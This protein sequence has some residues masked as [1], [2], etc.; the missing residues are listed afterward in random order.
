MKK[1][2][3]SCLIFCFIFACKKDDSQM[4]LVDI[5]EDDFV[6]NVFDFNNNKAYL[7]DKDLFVYFY[8]DASPSCSVALSSIEQAA[9]KFHKKID[10]YK[11]N[12]ITTNSFLEV[13]DIHVAPAYVFIRKDQLID[14][15]EKSFGVIDCD[16]L[17]NIIKKGFEI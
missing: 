14:N 15:F 6:E 9:N 4:F 17:E 11:I 10:F 13:F 7:G 3:F 5:T 2:L 1:I 16:S 12:V 8:S